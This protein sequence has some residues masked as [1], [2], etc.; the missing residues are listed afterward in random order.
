MVRAVLLAS[1]RIGPGGSGT[2]FAR[3][4]GRRRGSKGLWW[5]LPG[6][7]SHSRHHGYLVRDLRDLLVFICQELERACYRFRRSRTPTAYLAAV[8]SGCARH[9]RASFWCTR[10]LECL[11]SALG[12]VAAH[13]AA[14]L[15]VN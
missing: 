6:R 1:L 13:P 2:Y 14:C 15:L 10:F 8:H 9:R 11:R 3:F 12:G 4:C 7:T 5:C